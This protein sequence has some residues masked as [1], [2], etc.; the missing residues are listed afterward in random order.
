MK[1]KAGGLLTV[2]SA[3]GPEMTQAETVTIFN[4]MAVM[5]PATL[6]DPAIRWESLST[7]KV[8]A[9]FT[10]GA[11]TIHADLV[12]SDTG[13]LVNFVSDDRYQS[14]GDGRSVRHCDGPRRLAAI[15]S[16]GMFV[17]LRQ[18]RAAGTTR[19]ARI[20]TSN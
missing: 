13:E 6:I 1:V 18:A 15:V 19:R 5:A 2:A 16:S 14:S 4:D 20:R 8:R 11:Q 17:W 9:T 3:S 7:C 12:F 10:A